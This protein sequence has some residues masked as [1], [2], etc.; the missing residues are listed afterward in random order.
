MIG[1]PTDRVDGRAARLI[2]ISSNALAASTIDQDAADPFS[3][4]DAG[5]CPELCPLKSPSSRPQ[6]QLH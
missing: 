2:A 5:V 6:I 4:R 1:A 3:L